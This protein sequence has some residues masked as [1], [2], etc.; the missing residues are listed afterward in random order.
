MLIW[1][2]PGSGAHQL[3]GESCMATLSRIAPELPVSDLGAAIQHYEQKLGFHTAMR[4]PAGDYAIV[5]RDGVAIH[6]FKANGSKPSPAAI[7]IFTSDL[8]ELFAE[9]DRRGV[10]FSQ[11]I[12]RKPWGN[13]DFR[14]KD[15]FG[16]E[17]K[18]TEP[19]ADA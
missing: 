3:K 16:N 11:G 17:L 12:V 15:E 5:E 6:L 19:L 7:H 4:M 9:F 8:D 10:Q 13:R 18:F 1:L 2:S 14:L